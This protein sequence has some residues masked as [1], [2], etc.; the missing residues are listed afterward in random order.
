[1]VNGC[2]GASSAMRAW[3]S[4]CS[5]YVAELFAQLRRRRRCG[6]RRTA[7]RSPRAGTGATSR[8]FV[9]FPTVRRCAA[10]PSSRRRRP[11]ARRAAVSGAEI[12]R[13][14]AANRAVTAGWLGSDDSSTGASSPVCA[15]RAAGS[16]QGT[17]T[18]ISSVYCTS[19]VSS[20][21]ASTGTSDGRRGSNKTTVIASVTPPSTSV[22][23][24]S[25]Y[26]FFLWFPVQRRHQ[27]GHHLHQLESR[28]RGA[29]T[30]PARGMGTCTVEV[31]AR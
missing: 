21:I 2:C 20:S 31:V 6:P 23:V 11:V 9:R 19:P 29:P 14:P 17:A 18:G 5:R 10:C 27:V 1:M 24:N 7:R 28:S 13:S 12:S 25:L 8:E 16:D 30:P 15:G 4:T 22:Q 3:N 26:Q